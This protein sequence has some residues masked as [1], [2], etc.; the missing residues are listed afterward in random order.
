MSSLHYRA[1]ID[2]LRAVAVLPVVLFH[3]GFPIFEGGFVGVDI[4]FVISGYL[5]TS[6]L[7]A[8]LSAGRFSLLSFYER[9]ARRILPALF[10]TMLFCLPLVWIF[11]LPIEAEAFFASIPWVLAFL[12]NV[13]FFHDSGYF[14]AASE[15]KP[16]LHTWSLAIEEQFYIGFPLLLALLWPKGRNLCLGVFVVIGLISLTLA[17]IT[18]RT[19]PLANFYLIQTRLW[20]LLVGS[21][22]AIWLY[23]STLKPNGV[24]AGLGLLAIVVAIFSFDKD[25]LF[26]GIAALLPV[27]GTA[28][29]ILF[30]NHSNLVGK[31]LGARPLTAIGLISYS[32]YLLHQPAFAFARVASETHPSAALYLIL[33]VACM[34]LATLMWRFVEQPFR[35]RA[36]VSTSQIWIYTIISALA[37]GVIGIGGTLSQGF[38][39][40]MLQA[41]FSEQSAQNY[42]RLKDTI[43]YDISDHMH[44]RECHAWGANIE[45]VRSDVIASCRA[46]HGAPVIV[47]GDSHAMN[48]YNILSKA[49][50]TPF[51]IGFAQ[52]GCRPYDIKERCQ[53][54]EFETFLAEHAPKGIAR[55][56]YHQSGSY[57]I[58]DSR[59]NVDSPAAFTDDFGAFDTAAIDSVIAY[60]ERL[61]TDYNI[62]VTWLGPFV[63]YRQDPMAVF[64]RSAGE[65]VNPQSDQLF[66]ELERALERITSQHQSFDYV[67]FD[68]VAPVPRQT[69]VEGCFIFR[70]R[71]H[72]SRCGEDLLAKS[73][74]LSTVL[75]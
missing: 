67:G 58:A 14:D 61:G 15:L 56:I 39:T 49:N 25:T 30:A 21:L 46:S 6:I 18:A 52:P 32:L 34:G 73:P 50:I 19:D 22:V 45:D 68:A 55:I 17:E 44:K 47:L 35:N 9:R 24:L 41:K 13:F 5:I 29:I 26:P 40:W 12:S 74:N 38:E 2:G 48:V 8:D 23:G 66:S 7:L 11:M 69:W 31:V 1:E 64:E 16:L 70:D 42:R 20:E 4:F 28:M 36:N 63:E 33:I 75:E 62:Q 37:F 10:A 27:G 53:F 72:F 59:G 51:L 60:I 71:D 54:D 65:R 43:D 3:A 57:F